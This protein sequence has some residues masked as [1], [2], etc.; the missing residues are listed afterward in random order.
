MLAHPPVQSAIGRV[1]VGPQW[2]WVWLLSLFGTTYGPQ[3][4]MFH[5]K[6]GRLLI[7]CVGPRIAVA[8]GGTRGGE[9]G[10]IEPGGRLMCVIICFR[11]RGINMF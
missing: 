8:D 9:L 3:P 11:K 7:V 1:T 2:N 5:V 4:R 6:R 10:A